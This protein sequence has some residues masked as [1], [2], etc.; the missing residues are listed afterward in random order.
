[1]DEQGASLMAFVGPGLRVG[2]WNPNAGFWKKAFK[3]MGTY[4]GPILGDRIIGSRFE[5]KLMDGQLLF[6]LG[7]L[8]RPDRGKRERLETILII[9]QYVPEMWDYEDWEKFDDDLGTMEL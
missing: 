7:V 2:F 3:P 5:Q 1:M 9:D 8:F 4:Q 6:S